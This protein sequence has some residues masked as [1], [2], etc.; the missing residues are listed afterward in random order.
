MQWHVQTRS[1]AG[2]SQERQDLLSYVDCDSYPVFGE[3]L[4]MGIMKCGDSLFLELLC[5]GDW[6]EEFLK[7]FTW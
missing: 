3:T 5:D 4:A 7:C 2:S 1:S 6:Q